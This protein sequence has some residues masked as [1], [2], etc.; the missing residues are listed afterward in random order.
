MNFKKIEEGFV[1]LFLPANCKICNKPL[2]PRNRSLICEE[3]WNKV[4]WLEPPYCSICSKP[5]PAYETSPKNSFP[6]CRKCEK[7]SFHFK[8]VFA[9]TLYEGIMKRIIHIF[10][11]E[12]KMSVI[13]G[14]K[15]IMEIYFSRNHLP[16]S[17]LHMIVP[18]PLYRRKL[19]ERGFN[20]AELL[21][22]IISKYFNI[23]L[24]KN[25]LKRIKSTQSQTK[26]S[27][28]ERIKN[29]K[30]VFKVKNGKEFWEKNILLV[31]DIYTTGATVEEA[32]KILKRAKAKEIY[33]FVLARANF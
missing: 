28:N 14:I 30:G 10:K 11:Y 15:K 26:L 27:A 17:H 3:C 18:I 16:F 20:Q 25:N 8:K 24:N 7:N 12:K 5:L 1:S 21:A 23:K 2:N 32:A 4:E 33:V 22:R 13:K 6:I 31:D 19:K 9:L 29:V